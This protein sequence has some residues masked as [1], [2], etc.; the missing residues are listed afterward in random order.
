MTL[1]MSHASLHHV[2]QLEHLLDEIKQTLKP[3]GLFVVYEYIG[4]SQMQFPRRDL[5][6]ADVFLK[7]YSGAL[8]KHAEAGG[9]QRGS[10]PLVTR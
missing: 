5:E 4:P 6:L 10:P 8:P 7:R 2:F 9:R 1:F 3:G